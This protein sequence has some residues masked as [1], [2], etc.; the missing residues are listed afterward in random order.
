MAVCAVSPGETSTRH[1]PLRASGRRSVA[2]ERRPTPPRTC[3]REVYLPPSGGGLDLRPRYVAVLKVE[4]EGAAS[5][6]T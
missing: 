6:I 2:A 3:P 1:R 4:A 5:G